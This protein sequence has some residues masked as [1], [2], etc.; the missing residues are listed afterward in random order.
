MQSPPIVGREWHLS[1][2]RNAFAAVKDS[3][4]RFVTVSGTAGIGKTSLVEAAMNECSED[5]FVTHF[6]NFYSDNVRNAFLELPA[7]ILGL[8][9]DE[10]IDD[11][12][13]RSVSGRRLSVNR[14]T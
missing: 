9:Q 4:S 11:L 3:G 8:T 6:T 10:E 7:V 2:L 13:G 14:D 5:E 1:V 12:L